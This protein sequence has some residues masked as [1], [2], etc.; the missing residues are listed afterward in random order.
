MFTFGR[1]LISLYDENGFLGVQCSPLALRSVEGQAPAY[2]L[3]HPYGFGARPLD[4]DA[5]TGKSCG[6]LQ[7][8]DGQEGYAILTE[9]SRA[10]PLLPA[11]KP[12]ES[13]QYGPAG[14]FVRCHADGSVTVFTTTDGTL[15]GKSV[16]HQVRPDGFSMVAPWGKLTFDATGFHVLHSSG[17]RIDAGAIGGLPSPLDA[18]GSYVKISAAM[19]QIEAATVAIGTAAGA[20]E[21][22]AKALATVAAFGSV[23]TALT[24]VQ[25]AL[26]SL[27]AAVTV[28]AGLP[29]IT[30]AG[31]T[32]A[33]T[34]AGLVV[35]SA[36][37]VTATGT[38]LGA[39]AVTVPSS[40]T[41]T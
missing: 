2:Q 25:A 8:S 13:I 35:A 32:P 15:N 31:G 27:S 33:T 20:A 7:W 9:D 29:P 28:I 16:Y 38:L 11:L 10:T 21:P 26:A 30:A 3:L 5:A 14:N 17:A 12:G 23:A 19:A 24:A 39:T 6:V 41:V 22:A 40:T 4:A 37:A 36:A 34:A 1:A 18:L